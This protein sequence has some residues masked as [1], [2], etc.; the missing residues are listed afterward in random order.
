MLARTRARI[1]NLAGLRSRFKAEV[2]QTPADVVHSENKW[3]LLRYRSRPE[4]RRHRRPIVMVPSLINRYYV[5][6]LGPERSLVEYLVGEGHDVFIVDWGTP[7]KEDRYLDF[8]TVCQGYIGRAVRKAA[9][10]AGTDD[11]HLFG[12]CLG[13]TLTAIHAAANPERIASLTTLA[14]PVDFARGGM[15]ADWTRTESFDLDTLVRATGNVPWPLMQ[16]AFHLM[17]PTLTLSKLVGLL[18]RGWD[19]EFLDGFA[20]T[21]KWGNDNV[22]FP[23]AC[24]QRYIDDL[25]RDNRLV[26]GTMTLAGRPA[27]LESIRCPLLVVTFE[28]DNIVPKACA[29]LL[30]EMTSS[31]D[32]EHLHLRGGHVGAV[33]SRKAKDRLWM[34]LSRFW[35]E[36]DAPTGPEACSRG[37]AHSR[38]RPN[39]SSASRSEAPAA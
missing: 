10:L 6:D 24:Y 8:D 15:L 30:A 4:G 13:G 36:R 18:D 1:R 34:V 26:H 32:S 7:G 3:K 20:L 27:R 29:T 37:G 17:R 19:D 2:G 39:R 5:L 23:G 28:H 21:E 9:R 38:P 22:S 31:T 14:A 12:Y 16:A 33:V 11:V 25:Y 35:A